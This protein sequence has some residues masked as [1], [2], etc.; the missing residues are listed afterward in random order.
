LKIAMNDLHLIY[1]RNFMVTSQV[2]MCC[3]PKSPPRRG[4]ADLKTKVARMTSVRVF[5]LTWVK[6]LP[7]RI[8]KLHLK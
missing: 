3:D 7:M 2:K 5:A 1:A 4:T 6:F 8:Q